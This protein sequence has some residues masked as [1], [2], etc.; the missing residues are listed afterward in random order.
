MEAVKAIH[1]FTGK[2]LSSWVT[3]AIDYYN[4]VFING[5]VKRGEERV[6]I[7]LDNG[8]R[9]TTRIAPQGFE[10]KY[11]WSSQDNKYVLYL[12]GTKSDFIE[13]KYMLKSGFP[14]RFE[15]KY[16][17]A[18]NFRLF[19]GKQ[20]VIVSHEFPL[21]KYLKYTFGIEFETCVGIIPEELCFRD[22]LIPLR[23]GSISGNEYS[24]VVMRGNEGLSLL[25]QQL[26]TLRKYTHFN[27]E[28]S[29]HMH[30]GGYP[31]DPQKIYQ[32]YLVCLR[33]E[34]DLSAILPLYTFY[35]SKYKQSGKDYCNKL[36]KY[37]SFTVLYRNLVGLEYN[38]DLTVPHPNDKNRGHKWNIATRYYWLNL[39]NLLCYKSSKTVEFRFL[40]PTY[41]LERILFWIYTF[42]AI[43]LYA[44]QD[45]NPCD[46]L[47][48]IYRH[49]YPSEVA[50]MLEEE[51]YKQYWTTAQQKSLYNDMI[52][53]T[54]EIENDFFGYDSII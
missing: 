35:T 51:Y 22:G 16:E 33:L 23:D 12:R 26:Q 8:K 48:E 47:I 49:I 2:T 15:K 37:P 6:V 44:E 9:Y 54:T 43:M 39:I 25:Y 10:G 41:N 14:Y 11:F 29:L 45:G 20:S 7:V 1:S 30:F 46:S 34:S 36:N 27:K 32:L 52:G 28:C 4:G 24:T 38:G 42:N 50:D 31:L 3:V 18:E 21:A 13:L 53:A 17:A 40:R 19:S 5:F